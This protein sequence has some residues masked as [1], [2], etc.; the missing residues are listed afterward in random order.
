VRLL[1]GLASAEALSLV[2]LFEDARVVKSFEKKELLMLDRDVLLKCT[3]T[4][5]RPHWISLIETRHSAVQ[6]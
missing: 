3:G 1:D 4:L 2:G 6:I 5:R